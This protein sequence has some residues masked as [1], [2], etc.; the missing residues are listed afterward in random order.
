MESPRL[1]LDIANPSPEEKWLLDGLYVFIIVLDTVADQGF[2]TEQIE[3]F[4]HTVREK[5]PGLQFEVVTHRLPY[6]LNGGNSPY[7]QAL[8]QLGTLIR[9]NGELFVLRRE[10]YTRL[11]QG[12]PIRWDE[13]RSAIKRFHCTNPE[14]PTYIEYS[15]WHSVGDTEVEAILKW[16]DGG[17]VNIPRPATMDVPHVPQE[18]KLPQKTKIYPEILVHLHHPCRNPAC[19]NAPLII[20]ETI[21][22]NI[23][24][25]TH[26]ASTNIGIPDLPTLDH[27]KLGGYPCLISTSKANYQK[28]LN[29]EN[30]PLEDMEVFRL[31]VDTLERLIERSDG[32]TDTER[33]IHYAVDYSIDFTAVNIKKWLGLEKE[34]MP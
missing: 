12:V 30:V 13:I 3:A 29:K 4:S 21:G 2:T 22:E 34:L 14:Y 27:M 20:S 19:S 31:K 1:T 24:L 15:T 9:A 5:Y 17:F 18:K 23:E 16:I 28:L 10:P 11:C 25:R 33:T 32:S 8:P 26:K 7:I 6:C